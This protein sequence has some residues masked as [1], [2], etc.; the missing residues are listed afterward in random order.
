[1]KGPKFTLFVATLLFSHTLAAQEQPSSLSRFL[2]RLEL[3]QSFGSAGTRS[4]P[5]RFQFT[6]PRHEKTSYLID[7]GVGIP[8]AN[9]KI[10]NTLT[11]DG[12]VVGEYHRNT[13]IDE[14]QHNWQTGLS[15]TLRT[16]IKR[17]NAQTTFHQW[18]FTPTLKFSR[19][20]M[21]TASALLFNMDA[22]PFR[23][24]D[25][26]LNLNTY[27]I[28]GNRKLIHLF[29]INPGLEFQH[30][31]SASDDDNNGTILRPL[32]KFQYSLAGNRLKES[33]AEMISPDKTWEASF[34]YTARYAVLNSTAAEEEFTQLMKAGVDYYLLTRPL[35]IS[36]GV[37]FNYGSDPALG[38]KKQHFYLATFSLQ[39]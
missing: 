14:E 26:G 23:S 19:N 4:S 20:L 5:V 21:D 11:M 1:M 8:V 38:L 16:N 10:G 31:F 15:G 13:L 35:R 29:A 30:N 24:G 22:I 37:S 32:V 2:D 36:F 12:K 25:K 3:R 33:P 39:K 34:D 9:F 27:T 28:R 7:G 18:Y 6:I 17:N